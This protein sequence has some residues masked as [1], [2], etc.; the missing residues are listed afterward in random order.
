MTEKRRIN[1]PVAK[2]RKFNESEVDS[3]LVKHG[4]T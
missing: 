3:K 2:V 1:R 4:T